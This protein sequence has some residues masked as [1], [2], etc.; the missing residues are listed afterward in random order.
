[1]VDQRE[2]R[3]PI[4]GNVEDDDG[5]VVERELLP[6]DDL[7]EFVERPEAARQ[8]GE[9]VRHL[10]HELLALVHAANH[11]QV[12]DAV[13]S[14]LLVMEMRGDDAGDAAVA[15]EDGVGDATHQADPAAAVD[16]LD[17][18]AGERAT[19]LVGGGA[20]V[21]QAAFRRAAIDA[22]ALDG[23]H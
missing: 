15:G 17:A 22:K 4:A 3:R 9:G 7:E 11:P 1:V 18:G 20:I 12:A 21:R 6:G 13:M 8:D 10:E 14:D 23:G 5:L 16:Q 19:E 2:Q